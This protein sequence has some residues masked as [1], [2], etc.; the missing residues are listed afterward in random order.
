M[1]DGFTN[2]FRDGEAVTV[3]AAALRELSHIALGFDHDARHH[4][5]CLA[6]IVAARGF[7][8]KHDRIASVEDGI[9]HVAGLGPR[10][11][12]VFDH[13]L[14]HLRGRNY[15]LA[16]HRGAADHMLLNHRDFFR[17]HL[18]AQIAARDHHSIGGFEDLFEMV[19]RLRFFQLGN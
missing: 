19:N 1:G 5:H 15:G 13:R 10:G 12:R 14:E 7:R 6:G 4:S 17:R 16:P 8:R 11:T 2:S 3:A 18:D 9:G